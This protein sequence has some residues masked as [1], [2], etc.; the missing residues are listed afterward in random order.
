MAPEFKTDSDTAW[1]YPQKL[2]TL[3]VSEW[4]YAQP[5]VKTAKCSGCGMCSLYCPTG[6]IVEK[7]GYFAPDLDYCKGCGICARICPAAA[8]VMVMEL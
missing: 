5:V 2:F 7:D 4:R 3:K 1:A 6:C 8:V